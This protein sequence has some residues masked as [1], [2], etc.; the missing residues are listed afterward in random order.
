[1]IVRA[2]R[3]AVGRSCVVRAGM[4]WMGRG[5]SQVVQPL[6]LEGWGWSGVVCACSRRFSQTLNIMYYHVLLCTIKELIV[7]LT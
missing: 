6:G 5:R 3:L 4:A 1:M 7:T 2:L